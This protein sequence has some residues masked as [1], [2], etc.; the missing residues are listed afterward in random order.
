M[1][2]MLSKGSLMYHRNRHSGESSLRDT[3]GKTS[4][5][6]S[7]G[8]KCPDAEQ[9]AGAAMGEE[10]RNVLANDV[11]VSNFQT[12]ALERKAARGCRAA[13]LGRFLSCH[14]VGRRTPPTPLRIFS[15]E[16]LR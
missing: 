16:R 11:Q 4:D 5:P 7:G 12:W 10:I 6:G 14:H 9:E 8:K 3:C 1:H 15:C 2:T 13:T